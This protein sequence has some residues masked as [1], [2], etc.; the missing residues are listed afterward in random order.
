MKPLTS[1]WVAKA[2]GD[3][4]SAVREIRTLKTPIMTLAASTR[5]ILRCR[6]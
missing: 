3:F 5:S 6:T 4:H 2:E 1:E